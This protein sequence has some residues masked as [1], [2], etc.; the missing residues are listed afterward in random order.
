MRRPDVADC[1]AVADPLIVGDEHGDHLILKVLGRMHPECEDFW[2]GNWLVSPITIRAGGFTAH[3]DAALRTPELREWARGL[4]GIKRDRAGK[5][6]LESM[7]EWLS[8]AV[9]WDPDSGLTV[10]GQAKDMPGSGKRSR[11]LFTLDGLQESELDTW[12]TRL[13]A[14]EQEFPVLDDQEHG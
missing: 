2:D 13:D 12:V 9:R 4:Q 10:T 3:L 14:W 8:L 11:L 6:V 5:A 7:E 1:P